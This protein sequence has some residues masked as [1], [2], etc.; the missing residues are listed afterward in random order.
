M[1][2]PEPAE[3]TPDESLSANTADWLVGAE[4]GLAAEMQRHAAEST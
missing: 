4:E 3:P 1:G 2:V